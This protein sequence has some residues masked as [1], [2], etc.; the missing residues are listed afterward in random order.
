MRERFS[1]SQPG[2]ND[3]LGVRGGRAMEGEGG[4]VKREEEDGRMRRGV[5]VWR[6]VGGKEG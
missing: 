2:E 4:G 6:R 3:P 5:G 1:V